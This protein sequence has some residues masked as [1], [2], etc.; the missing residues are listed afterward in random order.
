MNKVTQPLVKSISKTAQLLLSKER[1]RQSMVLYTGQ[2]ELIAAE[3]L[4]KKGIATHITI[5]HGGYGGEYYNNN[6]G[7]GVSKKKYSPMG[8]LHFQVV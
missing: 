3:E 4:V 2:R 6:F 1:I 8:T 5:L 7:H